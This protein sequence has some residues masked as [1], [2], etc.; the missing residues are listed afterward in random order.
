MKAQASIAGSPGGISGTPITSGRGFPWP[1]KSRS[2][3]R[4]S[5]LSAS[6]PPRQQVFLQADA[7][8]A[9]ASQELAAWLY[10]TFPSCLHGCLSVNLHHQ[11]FK[12]PP[13]V[14][15][16]AQKQNI[17]TLSLLTSGKTGWY[18]RG[19]RSNPLQHAARLLQVRKKEG[20]LSTS[21]VITACEG[22]GP[23][24]RNRPAPPFPQQSPARAIPLAPVANVAQA[25]LP[26]SPQADAYI[27]SR[28]A[29]A[30]RG[31]CPAEPRLNAAL[32][33]PAGQMPT[34]ASVPQ[35]S[36]AENRSRTKA[37][38]PVK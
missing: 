20:M 28:P 37:P 23:H 30:A 29:A 26:G 17:A 8:R 2:S 27:A 7:D 5:G 31:R 33:L 3:D 1:G 9:P 19:T 12:P 24:H 36:L 38:P 11:M 13:P 22:P 16:S 21:V 35:L 14:R 18:C 25:W 4:G 6:W 32:R 34:G 10:P 15:K